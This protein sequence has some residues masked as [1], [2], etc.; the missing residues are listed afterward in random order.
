MTDSLQVLELLSRLAHRLGQSR[1]LDD[2]AQITF[3][4]MYEL[5][6]ASSKILLVVVDQTQTAQWYTSDTASLLT[7]EQLDTLLHRGIVAD[8]LHFDR[9]QSVHDDSLDDNLLLGRTILLAPLLDSDQ[10]LG[11]LIVAHPYPDAFGDEIAPALRAVS[12]TISLTVRQIQL[13]AQAQEI[14]TTRDRMINLLVH[15]IR[16]PLMAIYASIEVVRRALVN[17]APPPF[18]PEALETGLRTVR[19]IV[20]LTSDMLDLRRI[21]AGQQLFDPQELIF[22]DLFSEVRATLL[23]LGIQRQVAL[24]VTVT[25]SDLATNAD[26]RLMR[27]AIMNLVAN[28]LRFTTPSTDVTMSAQLADDGGV[29][30]TVEDRGPGV[31]SQDRERIFKAFVQGDGESSRGTGLG[32]ALCREVVI[33]HQG[34]IWVDDRLGGGSRFCIWLPHGGMQNAK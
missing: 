11:A 17:S 24:N 27:R 12:A 31:P 7:S 9:I 19:T 20:D 3:A 34:H 4:T 16:S 2:V 33:A 29:L 15:D 13:V 21:H 10:I 8:A 14:D 32:L 30:I 5:C 25:P 22:L 18:V 26:L 23:S 6:D 1:T 28:A